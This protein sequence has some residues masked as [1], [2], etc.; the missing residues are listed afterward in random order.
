M[1]P[2]GLQGQGEPEEVLGCSGVQL[3][4]VVVEAAVLA[5]EGHCVVGMPV[6][7][8]PEGPASDAELP[9]S[10]AAQKLG[11]LRSAAPG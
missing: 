4:E 1:C 9:A 2:V 6:A 7:G 8:A 11:L 5:A 10:G 3:E